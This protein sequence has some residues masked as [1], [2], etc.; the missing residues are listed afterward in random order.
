M[1]SYKATQ[2]FMALWYLFIFSHKHGAPL[3][4]SLQPPHPHVAHSSSHLCF[5]GDYKGYF[6]LLIYLVQNIKLIFEHVDDFK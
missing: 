4:S 6:S 5:V 1:S 2:F 3:E